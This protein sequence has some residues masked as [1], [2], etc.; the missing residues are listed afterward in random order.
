SYIAEHH[1]D[2]WMIEANATYRGWFMDADSPEK[3]KGK[4]YYDNY[5]QG[6]G[7][8]GKD[9]KSYYNGEIKMGDTPSLA[10]LMNGNPDDPLSESWGGNFTPINHSSRTI[11]YR[12]STT[13]DT[14]ATYSVL[15][16]RFKG[17]KNDIPEDSACF[18]LEIFNQSWPGYYLGDGNYGVRYSSKK[19]EIGS[20]ATTSKIPELN[21]QKGQYVSINPWPGKPGVDDYK[22]G[23]KWYSDRPDTELYMDD[24]QGAKTVSKYREEFLLDWAKRWDWLK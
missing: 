3:I 19:P 24:Q 6:R 23:T 20:Y 13:A 21:N 8:M 22:L 4:A 11:F 10:Y 12:N 15:E 2:L 9:F 1:P 18:T 14:V 16:W 5:I 7:A 17:P